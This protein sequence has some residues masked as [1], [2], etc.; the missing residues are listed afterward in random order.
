[1]YFGVSDFDFVF[2]AEYDDFALVEVVAVV[3]CLIFTAVVGQKVVVFAFVVLYGF[4]FYML[5]AHQFV[6]C[7]NL[8]FGF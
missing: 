6:V 8:N 2:V 4:N 1:M 3:A 5:P 7:L